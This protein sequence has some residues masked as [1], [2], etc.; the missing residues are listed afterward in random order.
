VALNGI[1][2]SALTA[3]QTNTSALKVVSQ[4]IANLNTANYARREVNLSALGANGIPAGVTM[5]DVT[6]VTNQYLTQECLSATS[7]SSQYSAASTF[8]DQINALLGSPGDGNSLTSK[9]SDVLSKLSSAQLSTNV[10]SSQASIVTSLKS[11][12][13]SISTISNSLDSLS[14][15][16]DAQLSTTVTGASTLIKQIYDYNKLI[17]AASLQGNTDTAYLDQ[18]DTA[19]KNLAEDMDIRVT[20]QAD[21]TVQVTTADGINLVGSGSYSVL[22]YTAGTGSGY[23]TISAQDTSGTSGEPIGTVQSLDSHLNA[24]AMRGLIDLRDTTIAGIKNELGSLTKGI[25]NAFNEIHNESSAYPPPTELTGHNTGLLA[26]DS[27]GFTGKSQFVLTNS[28]GVKQHTVDFN[29]DNSPP[30]M[31]VDGGAASTFTATVGGFATAL[32][33]ALSGLGGGSASF[34]NGVMSVDGGS[35]GVVVG[36]PDSTHPSSRGGAGLSQFFGLNDLLTTSVPSLSNTGVSG[37]DALGLAANG[38]INFVLKNADGSVAKTA[39]VTLSSAAGTTVNDAI[40]A[41]NSAL[42]G[43]A[44]VALDSNGALKTTINSNYTGYSLQVTDDS[45]MRGST[46]ISVSGLFGLGANAIG[47]LSSGFAVNSDIVSSPSRLALAQPNLSST[48]TQVVGSGDSN[49]LLALQALASKEVAFDKVGNLG[50]QTTSLQNYAAALYQDIATQSAN[51]TTAKSTQDDRLTE[52]QSRLS[53]NSG[54]NLDEELANMIMYQRAYSAG[55]RMLTTV[56]QLYDSL[57]SIQ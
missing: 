42:S 46:G 52:A 13:S 17:K 45:T 41:I 48:A 50:S 47:N 5:E 2:S 4:N 38:Q 18:R 7:S 40:T 49:G 21:G 1:L 34:A 32:N 26:G 39:S 8:F 54:V 6:R 10:G 53:N 25:T 9:L 14:A 3:M 29:F 30:T 35:Y 44:S 22:S 24:G 28:S 31:S 15:Q 55:A 37:T 16:A 11:L 27:L 23:G 56:N 33:G 19:L 12:T 57:L 20:P 43:Y 51:T 36:D